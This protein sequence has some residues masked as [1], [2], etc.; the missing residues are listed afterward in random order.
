MVARQ[1]RFGWWWLAAVALVAAC[2]GG[3]S[4]GSTT[5]APLPPA[6]TVATGSAASGTTTGG[7]VTVRLTAPFTSYNNGTADDNGASNQEVLNAVQPSVA[8]FDDHAAVVIDPN[9]V[10]LTKTSDDPL[11]VVYAFNP[12][13]VWD[14]GQPVGCDDLYLAWIA[15][16]GATTAPDSSGATAALF[17]TASTTGWDHVGAVDCS[18]DGRTATFTYAEPFS[19]WNALVRGLVPAHVVAAHAGVTDGAGIRAAYESHDAAALGRIA[20]FWNTGFKTD[21][22]VD[23]TVDLSA[24]PYRIDNVEAEQSVTLVPNDKYW[25]PRPALDRIVFRV[26]ADPAAQ[27]QAL[28]NGEVDVVQITSPQ[29]D[30]VG[31]LGGA[32]D[33]TVNVAA[34][35]SFEHFDFNFQVPL[36][37]DYTVRQA[38]AQC[39]PRQEIL[40]KLIVP[41]D[42]NATL[43]QSRM[44]FPG[45]QGY[46]D[47]SG[48]RYNTADIAGAKATLEGAGWTLDGTTYVKDGQRLEFHLLHSAA[49]ADEA[50][51]IELSCAQAGIAIIDD[52]DPKWGS[53]LGAGQFD[54]V[55]FTWNT[56]PTPSSQ[57]S[58][59]H[60]PP[61]ENLL[62][63]YGS[64]SSAHVDELLDRLTSVTDPTEQIAVANEMDTALWADLPTI[65]LWRLPAVVAHT[66]TIT[67][68]TANPT[69]QSITW[70]I[71]TWMR[72]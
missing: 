53:R 21:K 44:Y 31:L 46:A 67:G 52:A 27:A 14:D 61:G 9:L 22:G 17:N 10:T 38:V 28:A 26:I 70:N 3:G 8:K 13:A 39:L 68:V 42:P 71:E 11:V 47:T 64:Y 72:T 62:S 7:T 34:L 51:L 18:A 63:N 54:S 41:T 43:Q 16:N 50:Q 69:D 37:R 35:N 15:S 66:N 23:P 55:L 45:Q 12:A 6:T 33:V 40:D 60:T 5:S 25:G 58:L 57:E 24:G 36:L 19:D 65:P 2:S 49:R 29:P 4:S 48:G 1:R 32:R 20:D 56:S 30:V 59:Y